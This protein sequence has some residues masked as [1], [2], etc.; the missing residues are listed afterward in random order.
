MPFERVKLQQGAFDAIHWADLPNAN[1]WFLEAA[2]LFTRQGLEGL[3]YAQQLAAV[4][5]GWQALASGYKSLNINPWTDPEYAELIKAWAGLLLRNDGKPTQFFGPDPAGNTTQG[6]IFEVRFLQAWQALRNPSFTATRHFC[7]GFMRFML[8]ENA[9]VLEYCSMSNTDP[10]GCGP[11]G[12]FAGCA[13]T[14]PD[15]LDAYN[16]AVPGPVIAGCNTYTWRTLAWNSPPFVQMGFLAA[17]GSD[18]VCS[19]S[20]ALYPLAW[21]FDLGA[22]IAAAAVSRGGQTVL[23]EARMWIMLA[24]LQA[25]ID[26]GVITEPELLE[27]NE[28]MRNLPQ[29]WWRDDRGIQMAIGGLGAVSGIA[30]AVGGVYGVVIGAI[31]AIAALALSVLPMATATLYPPKFWWNALDS[32]GPDGSPRL[33]VPAAPGVTRTTTTTTT[34]TP[35]TTTTPETTTTT[36]TPPTRSIEEIIA[37]SRGR[38][39]LPRPELRLPQ[40]DVNFEVDKVAPEM[41]P[42]TTTTQRTAPPPPAVSPVVVVAGVGALGLAAAFI[43]NARK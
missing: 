39:Q 27:L 37:G 11:S 41:T 36:T 14:T 1:G 35:A 13:T 17:S 28:R 18:V 25:G 20:G 5:A 4:R 12:T 43:L 10:G 3:P 19:T 26:A 21:W 40:I 29:K 2:R 34:T 30:F 8:G 22:A 7:G 38:Y 23:L 24:N 32:S 15:R 33:D 9:N 16:K 6:G 31:A 42:T